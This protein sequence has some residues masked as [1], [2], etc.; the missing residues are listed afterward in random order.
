MVLEAADENYL[1]VGLGNIGKEYTGTRHNLGFIV[2]DAIAKK[3]NEIFQKKSRLKGELSQVVIE[4]KKIFLLKPSTYMNNSGEALKA[5][6]DFFKIKAFSNLL[7]IIDDVAIPFGEFRLKTEGGSGGHKGL[8]SIVEHLGSSSFIRLR[9]GV[10]DRKNG[11][12]A[13]HVLG[14]FNEVEKKELPEII[15]KAIEIIHLWLMQGLEIAMNQA[16]IRN[17]ENQK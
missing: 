4:G 11:D 14:N 13:S 7:V 9:V 8:G 6:I 1:I 15:N 16:N 17:K 2:V 3:Y 12:L 5:T 10:G